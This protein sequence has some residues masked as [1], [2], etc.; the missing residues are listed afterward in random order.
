MIQ[1]ELKMKSIKIVVTI[2]RPRNI[3]SLDSRILIG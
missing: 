1:L 3:R 2:I